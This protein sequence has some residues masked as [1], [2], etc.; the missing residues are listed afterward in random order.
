MGLYSKKVGGVKQQRIGSRIGYA[1]RATDGEL[2]KVDEFYFDDEIWKLRY[3]VAE[4]GSWLKGRKV[5]ISLAA[6]GE[7]ESESGTFSVSLTRDLV[8]SSPDI[9]T[10]RPIYRQHEVELHKRYQKLWRGRKLF[11]RPD[12]SR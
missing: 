2:G 12:G 5:L 9:D 7:A 11:H 1:V 6:I 10:Q 3:I 8:R 4:T